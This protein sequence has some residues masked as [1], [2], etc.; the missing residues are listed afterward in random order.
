MES[1]LR[2]SVAYLF[3]LMGNVAMSQSTFS[4]QFISAQGKNVGLERV[5]LAD[6]D[7]VFVSG[8]H[9]DQYVNFW[10]ARI[11]S[12]GIV[13]WETSLGGPDYEVNKSLLATS[14]GGMVV[15][16]H[17]W[18]Y[19][20]EYNDAWLV[21]LDAQGDVQWQSNFGEALGTDVAMAVVETLDGGY[22]T[23]SESVDGDTSIAMADRTGLDILIAH[24]DSLG[25]IVWERSIASKN[26]ERGRAIVPA[27]DG[28]YLIGGATSYD[29]PGGLDTSRYFVW[30]INETGDVLWESSFPNPTLSPRQIKLVNDIIISRDSQYL[31]VAL[32]T[33]MKLDQAGNLLWMN[34]AQGGEAMAGLPD[35]GFVVVARSR[36]TRY[37]ASGNILWEKFYDT[38]ER[39]RDVEVLPDGGFILAGTHLTRTDCEGNVFNPVQCLATALP[40]PL[41]TLTVSLT[42]TADGLIVE[43]PDPSQPLHLHLYD[44]TGRRILQQPLKPG[45]QVIH[46]TEMSPT[47][48]F[49]RIIGAQPL[50]TGKMLYRP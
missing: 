38:S 17:T 45:K 44:V 50:Q 43:V 9:D 22:L 29:V 47:V 20:D 37:D 33:V 35:G 15:T 12:L 36:L 34:A 27:V 8:M 41:E 7:R 40:R 6:G 14:D 23:V 1:G 39:Y 4:R 10:V 16:G 30:H 42:Q 49:Y 2:K 26:R 25:Q 48:L 13:E 21:K 32:T 19:A 24:H 18:S 3:I 46:L 31:L 28:G 11:N 5:Q